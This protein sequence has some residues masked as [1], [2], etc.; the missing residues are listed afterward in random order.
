ML[1]IGFYGYWKKVQEEGMEHYNYEALAKTFFLQGASSM[2]GFLISR[3]MPPPMLDDLEEAIREGKKK[4]A[5]N[6]IRGE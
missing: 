5:G 2:L 3:G 4:M 1:D 6:N